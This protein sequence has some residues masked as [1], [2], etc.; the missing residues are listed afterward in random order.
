M[1]T[2]RVNAP[3]AS[4]VCSVE[5]HKVAGQRRLH[6]NLRGF[7]VADFAD[8]NHVRI[9]AQNRAQPAR[10]TSGRIFR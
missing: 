2:S 3:G 7:L 1:S 10:E 4:L 8:Q 9:M 6:R 5:K